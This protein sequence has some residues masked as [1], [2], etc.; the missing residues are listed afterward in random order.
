MLLHSANP[1]MFAAERLELQER[2]SAL[3]RCNAFRI[4]SQNCESKLLVSS[5]NATRRKQ[6][7]GRNRATGAQEGSK[8]GMAGADSA[9]AGSGGA[10]ETYSVKAWPVRESRATTPS[11]AEQRFHQGMKTSAQAA[12][13]VRGTTCP[14]AA[15]GHAVLMAEVSVHGATTWPPA[16]SFS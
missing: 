1:W 3:H 14:G 2:A 8:E 15:P 10:G 12:P 13:H 6:T 4:C 7:P 11:S 5:A 16:A 9:M